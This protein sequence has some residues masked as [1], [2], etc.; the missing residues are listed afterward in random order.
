MTLAQLIAQLRGQMATKLEQRNG[1]ASTLAELRSQDMVDEAK[2]AEA[3]KAKDDLDTELDALQARVADLEAEQARDDAA[4]RLQ[5]ETNPGAPRPAYDQVARVGTE[6][7]TYRADQDRK[8]AGFARDVAAAFI[9]DYGAQARLARHMSEEQ[10][11]R[12]AQLEGAQQRAVG[13]GAFSGLVVPQYLIDMY[14]PMATTGRPFADACRHHDLPE[15]GM[16]VSL[17]RGTTGTSVDDQTAENT[18]VSETDYDDTL[19]TFPVRT[20]AGRQTVSRQGVDRGVRV[21]D[22]IVED[23]YK[24]YHANVDSKTLNLATVGLSAVA[25]PV[26]Y[27]DA[28]P[29][30]EELYPKIPEA[31]AGVEG[32]LLDVASGENIAVMHSRRWYW[33]QNAMSTKWPLISQPG[34]VEK[35]LGANYAERYGSGIR[36]VLPNGTP[37]LVDNNIA[38]NLGAGTN[39]D[40]IYIGD[41]NEFHLWEDPN[42]P[43]LIRAEQAKAESLGI[44]LVVYG[45]YAFTH[46]RYAHARKISG[47]GL[48]TPAFTGV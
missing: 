36:G 47:T 44:V 3:R 5:R 7:R 32:S 18:N 22:T 28:T 17:G 45:Y 39:E 42:A 30:A 23:L 19:L 48:I 38:T 26:T 46:T 43:V 4:D 24:R 12:G 31:L 6:E 1:Y 29:T 11:E 21:D 20:A 33:L 8:G 35:T 34:I 40:E 13:T 25:T 37:V 10:V 14:A 41:K 2:V 15:T 9:G 16:T 27:T